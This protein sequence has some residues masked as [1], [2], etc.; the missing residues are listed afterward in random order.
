MIQFHT[1]EIK[2]SA[3]HFTPVIKRLPNS[4]K[5]LVVHHAS[6]ICPELE[7]IFSKSPYRPQNCHSLPILSVFMETNI[8]SFSFLLE[9]VFQQCA[10]QVTTLNDFKHR[11]SIKMQRNHNA[12]IQVCRFSIIIFLNLILLH[13][14][15][16]MKH[17]SKHFTMLGIGH[18]SQVRNRDHQYHCHVMNITI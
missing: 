11:F 14:F 16:I 12:N 17:R 4:L 6:V 7:Q 15:V 8:S 13:Y 3:S 18:E 10:Q 9:M 5:A 1:Y 2:S